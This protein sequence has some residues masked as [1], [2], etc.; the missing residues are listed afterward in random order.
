MKEY[1]RHEVNIEDP[2]IISV[3]DDLPLWSAPFGLKLLDIIELKKNI[4]ALDLGCGLGFPLIEL[5]ERL[6]KTCLVYGIDPWGGALQRVG[7]KLRVYKIKNVRVVKGYAEHMP[8]ENECFDL[9]VSN[10]GIN[11]VFDTPQTLRECA[12]VCRPNAQMTFTLNTEETMREFYSVFQAVL[13]EELLD[14]EILAM[15]EH[16]RSKRKPLEEIKGLSEEAGF[17]IQSI[18]HDLFSLR[19][20][21]GTTMLNHYL[22]KYWFLNEWKKILN[23]NDRTRV[24]DRVESWLNGQAEIKGGISL[25]IPFVTFDCRRN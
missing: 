13:E 24:F 1:L 19:F 23:R 5:A 15:K 11:N 20:L 18:A 9:L 16:I 3:I 2:D 7:L 12:R 21:D 6:G 14:N 22:I 10:N 4:K 25:T 8:F 17:S